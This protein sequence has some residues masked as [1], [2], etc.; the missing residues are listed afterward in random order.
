[1]IGVHKSRPVSDLEQQLLLSFEAQEQELERLKGDVIDKR[2]A[3]LREMRWGAN[4]QAPVMVKDLRM[5]T[6]LSRAHVNRIVGLVR[7]Q[8]RDAIDEHEQEQG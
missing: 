4:G 6:K 8:R 2:N 7:D 5:A 3:L 1:M